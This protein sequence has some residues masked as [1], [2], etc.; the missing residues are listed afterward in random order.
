MWQNKRNHLKK[1]LIILGLALSLS[2]SGC[3]MLGRIGDNVEA[4]AQDSLSKEQLLTS[5]AIYKG[6]TVAGNDVSN[7]ARLV[8]VEK[9]KEIY[10]PKLD[11]ETHSFFYG[12]ETFT[13][14]LRQLG[15]YYDYDEATTAA[16]NIGRTGETEARLEQIKN[17]KNEPIDTPLNRKIN[18]EITA[19]VIAEVGEKLH[20]DAGFGGYAYDW[21][22]G[23]VI[24]KEGDPGRDVNP[25]SFK[26]QIVAA[27]ETGEKKEISVMEVR[28]NPSYTA[29]ADRVKGVIGS[30]T[31]T[32]NA[33]YW[34]RATNIEVSTNALDGVV[35]EPGEVFSFNDCIGDT[36]WDKGYQQAIVIVGTEQVPGM[37]GGVCQTSTT[38]YQAALRAD[39]EII[40]RVSHTLYMPYSD[41]G[42]DAAIEYGLADL[43]FKNPYDFPL[44]IRGYYSPGEVTFEILGDTDVKNY[45]VSL[46]SEYLYSMSYG[47]TVEYN[48]SLAP[49][50]S[51]VKT[52]GVT[53]SAYSAYRVNEATD[54]WEYLGDTWY[55]AVN[56]VIEKGPEASSESTESSG[57]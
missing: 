46:V 26:E 2:L 43:V 20:I 33:G 9:L 3:Q 53:G 54:E 51:V 48:S 41:G 39:M 35:I 14:S 15:Y 22:L 21:D 13:Y 32:F 19:G 6:A 57:E 16:Y 17:L 5:L 4:S 44:L 49:G 8:A 29:L 31:T 7:M 10:E 23:K 47:T 37:G 36:T 24:A 1:Y 38:I 56:E 25:E 42:L 45:E 40:D 34:E 28:T 27:V 12:D 11:E 52:Y 55:P 18:D 50:E 30:A